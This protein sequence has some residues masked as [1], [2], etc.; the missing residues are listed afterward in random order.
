M[1]LSCLGS[2]DDKKLKVMQMPSL[3][4][5][6]QILQNKHENIARS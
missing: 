5:S 3:A 4:M 6:Y 2:R 1:P